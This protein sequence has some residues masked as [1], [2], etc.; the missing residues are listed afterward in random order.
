MS[1]GQ[2]IQTVAM[3]LVRKGIRQ[4]ERATKN[5]GLSERGREGGI[6]RKGEMPEREGGEGRKSRGDKMK[7]SKRRRQGEKREPRQETTE[8]APCLLVVFVYC[9]RDR[10]RLTAG[11]LQRS[12]LNKEGMEGWK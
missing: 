2:D 10:W 11:P 8:R 3:K 7:G 9:D 12:Q 5:R 1:Q 6:K 4:N